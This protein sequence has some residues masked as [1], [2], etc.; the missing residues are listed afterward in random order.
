MN[1][2]IFDGAISNLA[3]H[4][5]VRIGLLS[6]M[7]RRSECCACP[8]TQ[9]CAAKD[10]NANDDVSSRAMLRDAIEEHCYHSNP[11]ASML[12]G[13]CNLICRICDFIDDTVA[14]SVEAVYDDMKPCVQS[15]AEKWFSSDVYGKNADECKRMLLLPSSHKAFAVLRR[16]MHHMVCNYLDKHACYRTNTLV[17]A[18]ALNALTRLW[19]CALNYICCLRLRDRNLHVTEQSNLVRALDDVSSV[20]LEDDDI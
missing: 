4:T 3:Y 7:R 5:L 15:P 19:S 8:P 17:Y 9:S 13:L 18:M 1:V 2:E 12:D 6:N 16:E 20:L 11:D 14:S 10:A